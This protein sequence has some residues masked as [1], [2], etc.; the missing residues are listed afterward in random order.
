MSLY[1]I[2]SL[3]INFAVLILALLEYLRNTKED[4]E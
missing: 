2:L 1:E 4:K 3:L